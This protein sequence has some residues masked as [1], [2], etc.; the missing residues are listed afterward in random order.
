MPHVPRV[1]AEI[2]E[3][4]AENNHRQTNQQDVFMVYMEDGEK[5]LDST[6]RV[7]AQEADA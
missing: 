6:H 5:T 4:K 1:D 7:V 2:V 3:E